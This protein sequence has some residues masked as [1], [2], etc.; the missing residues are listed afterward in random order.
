VDRPDLPLSQKFSRQAFLKVSGP[1]VH[2]TPHE[3]PVQKFSR[4]A[5]LKVS[6]PS[7]HET[8]EFGDY[9]STK[10]PHLPASMKRRYTAPR[11]VCP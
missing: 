6:G 2:E 1:S 3:T 11:K 4:Q 8:L 7:V 9:L 10:P 5:F